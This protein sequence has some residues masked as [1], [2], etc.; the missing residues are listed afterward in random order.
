MIDR[1]RY[2]GALL[3]VLVGDVLGAPFE[4]HAG[5]VPEAD[6]AG[7]DSATS[8][9]RFTDDTAMSVALAGSLV[10]MECL[11]EDDLAQGFAHHWALAPERGYSART[12]QLL[13]VVHS[14]TGWREAQARQAGEPG[15]ASNGAAMRVAPAALYTAGRIDTTVA[16]A[17][18]A[19]RVT[20]A[21]PGAING[22]CV[23]AAAVAVALHH[24]EG[25]PV[26]R[27]AF[28]AALRSVSDD[29]VLDAQLDLAA[30]LSSRGD[31]AEIAARIGT[32]ILV[33]EAVPAAVC[34]FL[35]HPQSFAEA[36]GLA[37][38][39]GGDTDTIAAMTGAI[40][41]ALLGES[42]IP[43]RWIERAESAASVRKLADDL[44]AHARRS[45]AG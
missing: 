27:A 19:A 43:T 8:M 38:R 41:G 36:V 26:D 15:R 5:L 20:H 33:A 45:L 35:S 16:V 39:L 18:R 6:I 31:A 22:A 7:I 10:R 3:G 42:A 30:E 17:R 13:S 14:G 21:H 2:R 1:A 37:V 24:P 23:Q 32:S 28:V 25:A 9:L 29:P 40:S 11:D 34:V 44:F 12:A 4:G